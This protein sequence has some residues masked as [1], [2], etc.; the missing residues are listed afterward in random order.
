MPCKCYC[1]I[2]SYNHTRSFPLITIW[3]YVL[4]TTTIVIFNCTL[5]YLSHCSSYS[6]GTH[7]FCDN[8]S[9]RVKSKASICFSNN[10]LI[11]IPSTA[12]DLFMQTPGKVELRPFTSWQGLFW[13]FE[14]F[15]QSQ[16]SSLSQ[17]FSSLILNR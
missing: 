7:T 3:K 8:N 13:T 5:T 2:L 1:V 10:A 17:S 11:M 4:N 15:V 16:N 14:H 9:R 12:E 6:S